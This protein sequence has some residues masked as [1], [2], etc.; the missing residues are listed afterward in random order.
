MNI[1]SAKTAT[2]EGTIVLLETDEVGHVAL[3][4]ESGQ[5]PEFLAL[6][7]EWLKSGHAPA[8]Y[9][10]PE[11]DPIEAAEAHIGRFFSSPKLIQLKVW[12]DMLPHDATPKLA[13]VF[14]W[15]A[16]VTGSAMQGATEFALP[17]FP[18][19]EVAAECA[20]QFANQ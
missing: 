1:L 10:A 15:T 7:E 4:L 6:Y 2:L 14:A 8:P 13:A 16:Q 9:Q 11:V 18:F 19:A 12:W 20:S 3:D 5:P 17:P